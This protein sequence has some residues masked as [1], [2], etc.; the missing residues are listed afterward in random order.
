MLRGMW[1]EHPGNTLSPA[2]GEL[3]ESE[4]LG[5]SCFT[6]ISVQYTSQSP[7]GVSLKVIRSQ[8]EGRGQEGELLAG[9]G[10]ILM[11]LVAWMW[12]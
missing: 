4:V 10:L 3:S 6:G 12:C 8:T 1:R 5:A 11:Q 7:E 9:I 2:G